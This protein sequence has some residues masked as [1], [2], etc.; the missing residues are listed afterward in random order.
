[1]IWFCTLP[2]AVKIES[3]SAIV[4]PVILTPV[5]TL[6]VT[7]ELTKDGLAYVPLNSPPAAMPEIV[8]K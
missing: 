4:P 3:V 1:M 2:K 8:V 7:A 5:K 6:P